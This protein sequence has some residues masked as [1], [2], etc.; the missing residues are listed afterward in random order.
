[1]KVLK[2]NRTYRHGD[3][4][5]SEVKFLTPKV[6]HLKNIDMSKI[7][8]SE[9]VLL[10]G[11][12]NDSGLTSSFFDELEMDDFMSISEMIASFFPD[13]QKTGQS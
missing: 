13:S 11:R 12:L 9:I 1:M 5:V 7:N 2:L 8:S 10:C 6:K 4:E 3:K